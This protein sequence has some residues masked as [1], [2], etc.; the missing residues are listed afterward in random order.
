M[1]SRAGCYYSTPL[2]GYW[3]AAKGDHLSPTIFN[4]VVDVV[5]RHWVTLVAGEGNGT[6]LL[7]SGGPMAVRIRLFQW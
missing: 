3:G 5:I 2:K 6:D 1:M 4:M 7:Q